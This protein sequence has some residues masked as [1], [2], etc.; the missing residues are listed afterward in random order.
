MNPRVLESLPGVALMLDGEGRVLGCSPACEALLGAPGSATRGRCLWELL[1]TR[2]DVER[3]RALFSRARVEDFPYRLDA[4][5]KG[6]QGDERWVGLVLGVVEAEEHRPRLLMATG[7][8]LT[9]Y[10][11]AQEELHSL[12]RSMDSQWRRMEAV[13]RQLPTGVIIRDAAGRLADY[14]DQAEQLLGHRLSAVLTESSLMT[15]AV[16]H[17]DGTP[18]LARELP[19]L[20][21]LRGEPT[22]NERLRYRRPDGHERVLEVSTEP[23]HD[24]EGHLQAGVMVLSDRTEQVH[25]E[26]ALREREQALRELHQVTSARDGDFDTR[27]RALLAMGCRRLGMSRGVLARAGPRGTQVLVDHALQEGAA[28][29]PVGARHALEAPVRVRG[30]DFGLLGFDGPRVPQRPA[31]DG[32]LDLLRLMAQWLGGE[33]EREHLRQRQQLLAEAGELL[34]ASLD[35]HETLLR[36][37][38]LFTRSLADFC[39]VDLVDARDRPHALTAMGRDPDRAAMAEEVLAYVRTH[40]RH[41]MLEQILRTGQGVL[42][43]SLD[44]ARLASLAQEPEH[45]RLMLRLAPRSAMMLPLVA[46]GR[47]LG[48][49]GVFTADPHAPYDEEDQRFAEALCQRAALA[50]DNA[51]LYQVARDSVRMRDQ[52]LRTI[53]H[54]LRGPLTRVMLRAQLLLERAAPEGRPL[55]EENARDVL[56]AAEQMNQ[57]VQDLVEITR[58]EVGMLRLQRGRLAVARL[59]QEAADGAAALAAAKHL[60]LDCEPPAPDL[61]PVDADPVRVQQIFSNLLGNAIKFTPPGGRVSLAAERAGNAVRFTV[62]DSGPGIPLE[63]Q[64]QLFDRFFQAHGGDGVG[65]GLGLSIVRGLV[66]AHGGT[67][68]VRSQPGEGAAFSF[69]LPMAG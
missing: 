2:E 22:R 62:V 37:A 23:I 65:L 57:L 13:L 4:A 21:A 31:S 39:L 59:L 56:R 20:R 1:S 10:R 14:N 51:R 40:D 28:V 61:P 58:I 15:D 27:A 53:A 9:G 16:L 26:Q 69:L 50:I 38:R 30:R 24:E 36:V 29:P 60:R 25:A 45:L 49:V 32:D 7:L 19:F 66:E 11:L 34:S 67:I 17:M 41:P 54:D 5:W 6:P 8:E 33:L 42:L 63:A 55:V 43:P 52:V 35:E 48:V 68:E 64:H 47:I 18:Y 3:V 12:L 46:R 44:E